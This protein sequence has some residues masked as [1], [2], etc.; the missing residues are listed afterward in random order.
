MISRLICTLILTSN[1]VFAGTKNLVYK[2]SYGSK[3]TETGAKI[4]LFGATGLPKEFPKKRYVKQP[5]GRF[6]TLEKSVEV[7]GKT[8]T[9]EYFLQGDAE[10]TDSGNGFA[11]LTGY[12]LHGLHSGTFGSLY[13]APDALKG[14]GLFFSSGLSPLEEPVFGGA[15]TS[16]FSFKLVTAFTDPIPSGESLADTVKRVTDDLESRGYVEIVP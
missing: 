5:F 11:S 13:D 6:R 10:P 16:K 2:G 8:R 1:L 4:V 9:L 12:V 14:T 15:G 3:N 7:K